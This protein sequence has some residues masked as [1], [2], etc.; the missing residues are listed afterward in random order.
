M[1]KSL[2][3]SQGSALSLVGN[4]D[5]YAVALVGAAGEESVKHDVTPIVS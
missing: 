4:F 2:S 5:G 3:G 1:P